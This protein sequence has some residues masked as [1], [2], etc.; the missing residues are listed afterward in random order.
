MKNVERAYNKNK[1]ELRGSI[2]NLVILF[3]VYIASFFGGLASL[4]WI[5]DAFIVLSLMFVTML[6]GIVTGLTIRA[7]LDEIKKYKTSIKEYKRMLNN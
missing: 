3:I 5:E 6:S 4:I 1:Q 7:T 2:T